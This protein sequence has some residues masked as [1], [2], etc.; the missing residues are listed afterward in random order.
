M[1]LLCHIKDEQ[2]A[3]PWSP[4]C[5]SFPRG[6][7]STL[8]N[9]YVSAL[10]NYEPCRQLWKVSYSQTC[11]Y[12]ERGGQQ[13]MPRV[14][15][16]GSRP[17][18]A[19]KPEFR[20]DSTQLSLDC[21]FH[22]DTGRRDNQ[23]DMETWM[24]SLLTPLERSRLGNIVIPTS[25]LFDGGE[26]IYY[27]LYYFIYSGFCNTKSLVLQGSDCQRQ[28]TGPQQPQGPWL[29]CPFDAQ[30]STKCYPRA[31]LSTF[32]IFVYRQQ[33]GQLIIW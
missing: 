22:E 32:K 33:R 25:M 26:C 19:C 18:P 14:L 4:C 31:F 2:S 6:A 15:G 1:Q 23:H 30:N 12:L 24:L 5:R 20:G 10:F 29:T 3:L 21:S 13:C 16:P 27:N 28:I 8:L 11:V 7:K 9:R 17:Y